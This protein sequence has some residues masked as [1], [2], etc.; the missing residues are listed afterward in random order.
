MTVG[1]FK[2]LLNKIEDH[3]VIQLFVKDSYSID[4]ESARF[5]THTMQNDEWIGFQ[6]NDSVVNID[7]HLDNKSVMAPSTHP[8][9]NRKLLLDSERLPYPLGLACA[10]Y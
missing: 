5:S 1:E 4:G 10:I 6:P 3:K 8:R 7:I 9:K 2:K